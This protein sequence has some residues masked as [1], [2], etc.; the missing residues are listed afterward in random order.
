[1][2]RGIKI[3]HPMIFLND[4]NLTLM[5]AIISISFLLVS[6][7]YLSSCNKNFVV[8]REVGIIFGNVMNFND[9]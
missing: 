1:M 2:L 5:L 6:I 7:N 8:V 4:P 9:H 3:F